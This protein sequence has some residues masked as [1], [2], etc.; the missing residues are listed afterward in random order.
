M[1][2]ITDYEQWLKE[3]IDTSDYEDLYAVHHTVDN[4]ANDAGFE[5]K[6]G[7]EVETAIRI[8]TSPA[9]ESALVIASEKMRLA[10]LKHLETKYMDGM[11]AESFFLFHRRIEED[12]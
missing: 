9:K 12:N 5:I 8:L 4:F 7:R 10:F 11:D 2:R 1:K 6:P 3:N